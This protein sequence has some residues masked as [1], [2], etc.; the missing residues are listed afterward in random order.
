MGT[1]FFSDGEEAVSVGTAAVI[2][3]GGCFKS[4]AV[5]LHKDLDPAG[6]PFD[7]DRY[8]ASP[9]MLDGIENQFPY[10][11]VDEDAHGLGQGFGLFIIKKGYGEVVK[12]GFSFTQGV[13]GRFYPE[14]IEFRGA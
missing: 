14:F 6:I 10:G 1:H 3:H 2:F 5:V 13:Q 8:P 9:G 12:K 7:R 11:L 4:N